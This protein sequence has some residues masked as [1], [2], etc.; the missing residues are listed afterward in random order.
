MMVLDGPVHRESTGEP[1]VGPFGH[2]FA[3]QKSIRDSRNYP[4]N[5]D[6]NA[7]S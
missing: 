5:Y 1:L 4:S 6:C 2:R 7:S 3:A